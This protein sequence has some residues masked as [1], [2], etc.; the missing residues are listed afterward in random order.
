MDTLI[1][2]GINFPLQMTSGPGAMAVKK[3]PKHDAPSIIC[4]HVD[5]WLFLCI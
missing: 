4:Q 3:P 2:L 5:M 1:K